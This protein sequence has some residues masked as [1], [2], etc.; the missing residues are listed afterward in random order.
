[1]CGDLYNDNPQDAQEQLAAI[2][3]ADWFAHLRSIV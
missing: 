2:K 3:P 1:M